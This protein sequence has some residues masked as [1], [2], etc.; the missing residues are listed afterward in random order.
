MVVGWTTISIVAFN[1][2][3]KVAYVKADAV[4]DF[5]PSLADTWGAVK[6]QQ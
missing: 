4:T 5:L 1:S 2:S 6:N 3:G